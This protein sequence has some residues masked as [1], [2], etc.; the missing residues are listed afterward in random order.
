MTKKR[1]RGP[2]YQKNQNLFCQTT[3]LEERS[4]RDFPLQRLEYDRYIQEFNTIQYSIFA[5]NKG[6]GNFEEGHIL[7]QNHGNQAFYSNIKIKRLD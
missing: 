2:F 5:P 7:F 1:P 4:Y 6:F 3:G